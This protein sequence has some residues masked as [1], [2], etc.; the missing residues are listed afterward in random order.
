MIIA[1]IPAGYLVSKSIALFNN[2]N[3]NLYI[4]AGILG[5]VAPDIDVI[6]FYQYTD[7]T[8][9]HHYFWSH[10][11]HYWMVI[12]G[13]S[14]FLLMLTSRRFFLAGIIFFSNIFLHLFLD[15]VVGG[16]AWRYPKDD[17]LIRF[18]DVPATLNPTE[19]YEYGLPGWLLNL[20]NHWTFQIE[21]AIVFTAALVFLISCISRIFISVKNRRRYRNESRCA[22]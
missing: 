15:T 5:S 8:V 10:I 21:I 11:P 19:I 7:R 2:Q 1:H 22:S 3:R 18:I 13:Y 9:N 12:A 20:M 14:L 4:A 16:I 6:Y 17:T